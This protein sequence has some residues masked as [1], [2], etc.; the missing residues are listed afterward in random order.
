MSED[1]KSG[2]ES[3]I[4]YLPGVP[5]I[6]LEDKTLNKTMIGIVFLL[7]IFGLYMGVGYATYKKSH[8]TSPCAKYAPTEITPNG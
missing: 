4:P 3:P 1:E 5:G 7:I 6:Y 8:I 2:T